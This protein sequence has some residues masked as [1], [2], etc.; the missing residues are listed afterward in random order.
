MSE[1]LTVS[2]LTAAIKR[3]LESSFAEVRVVGE[4]SRL[5]SHSSGHLYFTIKDR[6]AAISAVIW[7]STAARLR[8]RP[9][10]G[11]EF[12]FA[13]YLSLYEP[14]GSY[15]LIV[16]AVEPCGEGAL[17]AEFE[18]RKRLFAERGWFDAA[19]KRPLP[20]LPRHIGIVTSPTAAAFEDVRKVL[21]S[22]PG[23]LHL[24][25]APAVVQGAAAPASV[26]AA[27]RRLAVL[28]EPPQAILL[29]RGGGSIED[30]WCFNDEALV[31]AVVASPIPIISGIGHEIDVTLADLAADLRAATPSNAAELVC[32]AREELRNRLPRLALWQR[33]LRQRIAAGNG[34]R[35]LFDRRLRMALRR[36]LDRQRL[37]VER[38]DSRLRHSRQQRLHA[39]ALQI[40]AL[41]ARLAAL[42]PRRML[43]R[44]FALVS[45]PDGTIVSAAAGL[46]RGE[47][48]RLQF[49]DDAVQVEVRGRP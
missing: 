15:Q 24:T 35:A 40:S 9:S 27:L 31:A 1:A 13:G 38:G 41:G 22:R 37:D 12:L 21:A 7:K 6:G 16:T 48:L 5:T 46:D 42:D 18:R 11:G 36:Q 33:L 45:R 2:E 30:L 44:G 3:L 23:W 25:L 26:A 4:V 34:E 39:A 10:E 29:V 20:P 49:H 47:K 14:R 43:A 17:A 28:P 19:R 32:P 8:L